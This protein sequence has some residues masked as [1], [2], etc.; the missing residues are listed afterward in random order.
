M[1]EAL[2]SKEYELKGNSL[3]PKNDANNKAE[4]NPNSKIEQTL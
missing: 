2:F 3:S 1:T 4:P